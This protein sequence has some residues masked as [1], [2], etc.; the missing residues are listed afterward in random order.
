MPLHLPTAAKGLEKRHQVGGNFL[1]ALN[2]LILHLIQGLLTLQYI[3]KV[4]QPSAV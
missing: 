2:K 4:H 3:E 1:P